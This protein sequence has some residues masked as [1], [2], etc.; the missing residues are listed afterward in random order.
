MLRLRDDSLETVEHDLSRRLKR[1]LADEQNEVLDRLRRAGGKTLADVLPAQDEQSGR[2]AEAAVAELA[3]AAT[4]GSV[5]FTR[6][7]TSNGHAGK[8][9]VDDLADELAGVIVSQ[10][11]DRLSRAFS[12]AGGDSEELADRVRSSYREWKNQR[13]GDT[14][15]HYVLAAFTRGLF[16][17]QPAG[18]QLT[19][20]VDD[21]GAPC[22]DAE[23]NALAGLVVKGEP[24]PTGHCYPPA[25][26]GCRC[27][28]KPEDL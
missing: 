13:I 10:L 25:H 21:G 11:R 17:A 27:L 24:F 5:F 16:E 14:S 8:A 28:V 18:T 9:A 6:D 26:P 22:P 15:R 2:Y 3:G 19:W 12:E 1:V 20:V 23:D 7:D 4:S